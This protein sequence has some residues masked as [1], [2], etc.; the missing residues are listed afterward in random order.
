MPRFFHVHIAFNNI[1]FSKSRLQLDFI[2]WTIPESQDSNLHM[3]VLTSL[4]DS[5]LQLITDMWST[6]SQFILK[7]TNRNLRHCILSVTIDR[8]MYIDL[9]QEFLNSCAGLDYSLVEMLVHYY[10]LSQFYYHLFLL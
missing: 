10:L 3:V 9:D 5:V 8:I 2:H 6:H 4:P 1:F 7:H